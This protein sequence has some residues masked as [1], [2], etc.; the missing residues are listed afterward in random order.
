LLSGTFTFIVPIALYSHLFVHYSIPTY[1]QIARKVFFGIGAF[2]IMVMTVG[3]QQ[4]RF[5]DS[6]LKKYLSEYSDE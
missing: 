2:G 3:R 4:S 5:I 6:L 1:Y